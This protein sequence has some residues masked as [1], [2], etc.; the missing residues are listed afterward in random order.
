MF[1]FPAIITPTTL[2]VSILA[3]APFGV[4]VILIAF[5]VWQ[6]KRLNKIDEKLKDIQ[7]KLK[8]GG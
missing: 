1:V 2:A 8:I 3:L 4:L 6:V 7:E 5:V